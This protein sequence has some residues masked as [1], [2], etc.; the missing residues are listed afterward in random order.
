MA[1]PLVMRRFLAAR[2]C[3][4]M[5][6]SPTE[7]QLWDA[8]A[9]LLPGY[10]AWGERRA[11]G[12]VSVYARNDAEEMFPF[13]DGANLFEAQVAALETLVAMRQQHESAGMWPAHICGVPRLRWLKLLTDRGASFALGVE[14]LWSDGQRVEMHL[15]IDEREPPHRLP[16]MQPGW[17]AL[18][19]GA[20]ATRLES[21]ARQEI[22]RALNTDEF[23]PKGTKLVKDEVYYAPV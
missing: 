7:T 9:E 21:W 8:L 18:L 17:R 22:D 14:T 15:V 20:E 5:P 2:A 16:F 10:K 11:E 19:T 4:D 13:P 12:K 1:D 3:L 23:L 6:L